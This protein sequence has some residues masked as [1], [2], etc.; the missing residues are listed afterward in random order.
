MNRIKLIFIIIGAVIVIALVF[1]FGYGLGR[2]ERE[3]A[4]VEIPVLELLESPMIRSLQSSISGQVTEIT[5][6]TLS[7]TDDNETLH[8]PIAPDARV[9][10]FI[11][12]EEAIEE[13]VPPLPEQKDVAF[14]DIKVNDRVDVLVNVQPDG[15]IEGIHII[16]T[17]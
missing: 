14:E 15:R 7:V 3:V 8:I 9:V 12:P 10:T 2:K 17:R 6:R 16:I 11:L 1:G 4:R 5:N 13:D